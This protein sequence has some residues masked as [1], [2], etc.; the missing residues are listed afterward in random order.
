MSS[1]KIVCLDKCEVG[2]ESQYRGLL[3]KIHLY[4]L[5]LILFDSILIYSINHHL[6]IIL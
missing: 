4:R 3:E 1:W 5:T 2:L 6:Y